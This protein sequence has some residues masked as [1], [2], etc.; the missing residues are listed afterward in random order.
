[1]KTKKFINVLGI[2]LIIC[3]LFLFYKEMTFREFSGSPFDAYYKIVLFFLLDIITVLLYYFHKFRFNYFTYIAYYAIC[4]SIYF[5][6]KHRQYYFI[7]GSLLDYRNL[8]YHF[9]PEKSEIIYL[10]ISNVILIGILR[11]VF[12]LKYRANPWSNK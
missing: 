3:K 7:D 5:L 2:T 4:Y 10:I 12:T 1:M 6:F 9:P 8:H 11:F